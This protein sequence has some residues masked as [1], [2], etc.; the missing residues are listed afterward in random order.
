MNGILKTLVA[1]MAMILVSIG[2]Y[3]VNG[4]NDKM[5]V[6]DDLSAKDKYLHG[7]LIVPAVAKK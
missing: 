6:L 3:W 4:I 1:F 5:K 2:T 7:D